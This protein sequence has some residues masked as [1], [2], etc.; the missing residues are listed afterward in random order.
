MNKMDKP[1]P[2]LI[3][4]SH[5]SGTTWVGKILAQHRKVF[6]YYEPFNI[7]ARSREI[8]IKYWYEYVT[9]EKDAKNSGKYSEY[10][11][12]Y[13]SGNA[14]FNLKDY[15]SI[16]KYWLPLQ[17]NLW[18]LNAPVKLLKDPLALFAAEW[19]FQTF[20]TKNIVLIRHPAAFALSIMEKNWL[21]DF[22]HFLA[23]DDLMSQ[24]LEKHRPELQQLTTSEDIIAHAILLWN[25]IHAYIYTLQQKYAPEWFFVTHEAISMSPLKKFEEIF[26]FADLDFT[27][28]IKKTIQNTTQAKTTWTHQYRDTKVNVAKWKNKLQATE[29]ERIKEG[30]REVWQYFYTEE[31]W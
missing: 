24:Y 14:L 19:I 22:N 15:I 8:P 4:G 23:Q 16:K 10:I 3:S 25:I 21:H 12:E 31:D 6:Y 20:Q 2:I 26:A 30:T 7:N 17:H 11:G 28:K 1:K 9:E 29:I 5:R 13:L 27:E 18:Q